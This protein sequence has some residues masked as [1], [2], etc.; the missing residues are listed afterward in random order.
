MRRDNGN[1][2]EGITAKYELALLVSKENH[3]LILN[4]FMDNE[5]QLAKHYLTERIR[6]LDRKGKFNCHLLASSTGF[7]ILSA[8]RMTNAHAESIGYARTYADM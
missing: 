5:H 4:R 7:K 3:R 2:N 1:D 6:N 8:Q